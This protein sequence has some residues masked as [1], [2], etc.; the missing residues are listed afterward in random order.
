MATGVNFMQ[1]T[2]GDSDIFYSGVQLRRL[3]G[4][5]AQWGSQGVIAP[6]SPRVTHRAAGANFSV[7]IG[8][9]DAIV[10]GDDVASQGAYHIWNDTAA[11]NVTTPSAPASSTRTHRLVAQVRDKRSNASYATYDW[12]PQLLQDTGS[13]TPAEPASA[14]TLALISISAGQANVAD[15]NITN[16]YPVLR[17]L[18]LP[19]V[20]V[21]NQVNAGAYNAGGSWGVFSSANWPPITFTVP[22]S[23]KVAVTIGGTLTPSG[24]V[25]MHLGWELTGVDSFAFG[26]R[27]A[28]GTS[29]FMGQASRRTILTGLTPG[30]TDTITPAWWIGTASSGTDGADGQ[31]TVEPI[32]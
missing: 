18:A 21:S 19:N 3:V 4:A 7:D 11:L 10:Y 22:P 6:P 27:Q 25:I 26:N 29:T 1:P 5:L 28:V 24:S 9:L 8:I 17:A 12:V 20:Q 13:G 15:S 23:G 32:A 16:S 2:S 30:A 14:M 31:L